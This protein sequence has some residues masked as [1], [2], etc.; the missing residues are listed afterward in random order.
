MDAPLIKAQAD[1][2]EKSADLTL[3]EAWNKLYTQVAERVDW[4][5]T[6]AKQLREENSALRKRVAVLEAELK[7]IKNGGNFTAA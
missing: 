3:G 6:E 2:T 4:L 5:E 1:V 7:Q